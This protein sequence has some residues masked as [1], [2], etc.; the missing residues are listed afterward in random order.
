MEKYKRYRRERWVE[1][2]NLETEEEEIGNQNQTFSAV[3]FKFL[4]ATKYR[5]ENSSFCPCL[6]HSSQLV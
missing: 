4:M 2:V 5:N 1:Y 6:S 3:F